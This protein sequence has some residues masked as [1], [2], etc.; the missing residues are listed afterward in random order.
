MRRVRLVQCKACRFYME[1]GI[2]QRC[3]VDD[4]TYKTWMGLTY[5]KHP[6]EINLRGNC[7]DYEEKAD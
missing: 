2:S 4:N 5:K 7:E 3:I 6:S 1:E